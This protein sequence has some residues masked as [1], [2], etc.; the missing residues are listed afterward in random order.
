MLKLNKTTNQKKGKKQEKKKE[1]ELNQTHTK[2]NSQRL[3]VIGDEK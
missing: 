1:I 2:E 3:G